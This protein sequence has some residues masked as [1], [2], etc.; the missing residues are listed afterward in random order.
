MKFALVAAVL[1]WVGVVGAQGVQ[2]LYYYNLTVN[3]GEMIAVGVS[4]SGGVGLVVIRSS[5]LGAFEA[6]TQ[7]TQFYNSTVLSGIY[8]IGVPQGM[9]A[10]V[11]E[12]AGGQRVSAS[13]VAYRKG[14]G[15]LM[16]LNPTGSRS[17]DLSNY[18]FENITVLSPSSFS[19]DP[20]ALNLS[21]NR[22]TMNSDA[23]LEFLNISLNR[24]AYVLRISA[25]APQSVFVIL[26]SQPSIIDPLRMIKP[27]LNYPIGVASYGLYN[28]SGRISAYQISTGEVVGVANISDMAA[29]DYNYSAENISKHGA[30]LQLNVE[31]NTDLGGRHEVFWLQDVA[32]FDTEKGAMYAVDNVWNNTVP[33]GGLGNST[34]AGKGSVVQC[35][36]C[37]SGDF[38]AYSYPRTPIS[39]SLP[40]SIKL[41]IAENQTQA[42]TVLYFGYQLLGNGGSGPGPLV[43]YDR[44]LIPGSANSQL[45]VTPYYSTPGNG[46]S[47]GSYYDAELVFGGEANGAVSN[48]S[49]M[50]AALWIYYMDNGTLAPFPSAYT[51]G[52]S[53]AESAQNIM[54]VP[55]KDGALALTGA[56]NFAESI[57][58]SNSILG[59]SRYLQNTSQ[60]VT[61][62]YNYTT[63]PY[64][65]GG[66]ALPPD[67]LTYL[68]YALVVVLALAVL[69]ELY[70][71]I[72]G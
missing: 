48:F 46:G 51:F 31:L 67:Y 42:G 7:V 5:D 24:G 33:A 10:V 71:I 60:N 13:A 66:L 56:P 37:R 40:L 45:L 17:I 55:Y 36:T 1:L 41:V 9:Y 34:L 20:L 49:R 69:Y 22:F 39:Y 59:I 38:Y 30:S 70:R 53:T 43:F 18:S 6:G 72:R 14:T 11:F 21:G 2:N 58:V 32:D 16:A 12:P 62:A 68:V 63:I 15:Y 28:G 64:G 25:R 52:S 8:Q 26:Y 3:Y 65:S 50:N 61:A 29:T 23:S 4:A 27:A 44:V 54:V 47:I 19:A 57:L 35:S